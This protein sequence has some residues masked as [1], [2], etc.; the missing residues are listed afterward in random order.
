MKSFLSTA[1][2]IKKITVFADLALWSKREDIRG[3][4][5]QIEQDKGVNYGNISSLLPGF[6]QRALKNIIEHL[7]DQ[8]ILYYSHEEQTLLL[9]KKGRYCARTG[10]APIFERGIYSFWVTEH[11]ITG[12]L[13]LHF[14]RQ[15]QSHASVAL[16][17]L[18]SWFFKIDKKRQH[19]SVVNQDIFSVEKFITHA[20]N[21]HVSCQIENA[22]MLKL[23]WNIDHDSNENELILQGKLNIHGKKEAIRHQLPRK[24]EADISQLLLSIPNWDSHNAQ[25]NIS[26]DSASFKAEYPESFRR[27]LDIDPFEFQEKS[28]YSLKLRQANIGPQTEEDAQRWGL[29]LLQ[30]QMQQHPMYFQPKTL[31]QE[32]KSLTQGTPLE[33]TPIISTKKLLQDVHTRV[34]QQFLIQ[35]HQDIQW[36]D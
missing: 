36:R 16:Q 13:L 34:K 27:N 33:K 9:S 32:W 30:Y 17:P 28:D 24:A 7:Q 14:E 31:E 20:K 3:L 12:T 1:V 11:D 4:C 22:G 29:Q 25:L 35:A 5:Q 26:L 23:Q 6:S 19:H 2:N 8:K 10:L 15:S 18:P 21:R